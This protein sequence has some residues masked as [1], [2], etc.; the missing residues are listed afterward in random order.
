MFQ[1][2]NCGLEVLALY[3]RLFVAL[4]IISSMIITYLSGECIKVQFGEMV[5]A[6]NPPARKST[7]KSI[8]FGADIALGTLNHPDCNGLET[9]GFGERRPFLITGPGEYEIKGVSVRGFASESG[10]GGVPRQNTIYTIMLEGMALCFL[11]AIS[12]PKLPAA[13]TEELGDIDVLFVPIGGDGVLAP[14]AAYALAVSLSPR[15]IIPMHFAGLGEPNALQKFLK[16]A[17]EKNDPQ[18]KLTLKKKDLEGKEGEVVVLKPA[19]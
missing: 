2:K 17:G 12:A 14:A 16:E 6:F 18:E 11:G 7:Q 8:R 9:L 19:Q 10:Y 13:L 5:L 4:E 1:I 3:L 15:L